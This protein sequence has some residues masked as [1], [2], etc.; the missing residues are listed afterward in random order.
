MNGVHSQVTITMMERQGVLVYPVDPGTAQRASVELIR[1][2]A[3]LNS[4]FFHMTADTVGMMR[5]GVIISV[6]ARLRPEELP[7]QKQRQ[8]HAED[9]GKHNDGHGENERVEHDPPGVM[10]Q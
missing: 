4:M 9:E 8:A 6:R 2:K 10:G 3:G 1:P 7:G 5:K